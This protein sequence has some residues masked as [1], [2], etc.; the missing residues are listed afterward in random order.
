MR[1]KKHILKLLLFLLMFNSALTSEVSFQENIEKLVTDIQSPRDRFQDSNLTQITDPFFM[2][3]AEKVIKVDCKN[4]SLQ[5][6]TQSQLL[7]IYG[8]KL[9]HANK[10]VRYREKF[11]LTKIDDLKNIVGINQNQINYIRIYIKQNTC[12]K[13]K[14]IVTVK[15]SKIFKRAKTIHH[16]KPIK[17]QIILNQKVKISDNW[18]KVGDK[19]RGYKI[20]KIG[21]DFILIS[22]Q[23][24]LKKIGFSKNI[25]YYI[26]ISTL[27]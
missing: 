13:V 21:I 6:I 15:K 7:K 16:R 27:N 11:G 25:N 18:Y 9:F 23:T 1:S 20:S 5:N 3:K 8:I 10:I 2:K 22:K 24:T 17:L 4:F 19:I 14:K 12:K 26:N